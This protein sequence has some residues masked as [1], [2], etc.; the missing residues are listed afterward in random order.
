MPCLGGPYNLHVGVDVTNGVNVLIR[1]GFPGGR[2]LP[3]VIMFWTTVFRAPAAS[4]RSAPSGATSEPV[5]PASFV[6]HPAT[7]ATRSG[8]GVGMGSGSDRCHRRRFGPVRS[9]GYQWAGSN[10]WW[11]MWK[12][13]PHSGI[14]GLQAGTRFHGLE[15]I[16]RDRTP[17]WGSPSRK[18]ASV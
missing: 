13:G 6:A 15:S 10:G 8:G 14:G 4:G 7:V 11:A 1:A 9:V 5:E 18:M 16:P 17:T 12:G 2:G 3:L